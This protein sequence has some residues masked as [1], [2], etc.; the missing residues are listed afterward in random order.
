MV[1]QTRAEPGPLLSLPIYIRMSSKAQGRPKHNSDQTLH[2]RHG[3]S[4]NNNSS[5]QGRSQRCI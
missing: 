1:L 2:Q 3:Q 4:K 5:V